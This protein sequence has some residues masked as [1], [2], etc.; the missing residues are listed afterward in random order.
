VFRL[1]WV[2]EASWRQNRVHLL[3]VVFSF[4]LLATA[5]SAGTIL[6]SALV[7][8]C[9]LIRIVVWE[10]SRTGTRLALRRV[11]RR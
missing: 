8:G 6:C 9:L 7:A 1:W 11:M 3:L 4:V 2:G 10:Y 5:R